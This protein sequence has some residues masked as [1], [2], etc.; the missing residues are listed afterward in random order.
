MSKDYET[1]IGLEI[2]AELSTESK[3][4][5]GCG[6][7]FGSEV[8]TECCPVCI[9]LPG[10]LPV[11]SKKVVD[12][13][14]K[15]GLA[16]GCTIN[17]QSS[18]FRKNYFYPDLP[19]GYQIT[20]ADLPI[21]EGG[22]I[23]F[24][25]QGEKRS[26]RLIRIHLEEDTAKLVH[27]D[28]F[29]GTLLDFNR[30]GVPLIEI[31][32]E[33]DLRSPEEVKDYLDAVRMLLGTLDI[34]NTQMQEGTIR[35]DVNVS[36]RPVGQEA[37]GT[38]VEMKNVST[39]SGAMQAVA[40]E[41]ARQI[42]LLEEGKTFAQETRRWDE[43]KGESHPMRLKETAADYRYFPEADLTPLVVDDEWIEGVK[44]NL[45]ELPVPKYERYLERGIG[46]AEAKMLLEFPDRAAFFESAATGTVSS[47]KNLKNLANWIF[48]PVSAIS[49][50]TAVA[51]EDSKLKP[52]DLC[53][54][55]TMVE[56]KRIN[57]DA[58]R[59][60][61]EEIFT[62]GGTAEEVVKKL[63][64]EQVSDE[65]ALKQLVSEVL[66]ANEK[67]IEDYRNGKKNAFTFLVGQCMKASKGKGNPQVVNELLKAAL[68]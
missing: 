44:K 22:K 29:E 37:F 55:L 24:Y 30:C 8:N 36:V 11:L 16:A 26:V 45:P 63:S 19:H 39:F 59:L 42:K 32:S 58:G 40:Y 4:F 49:K 34:C 2:H 50:K 60:V 13:A 57:I 20:Q 38:R 52:G 33:P 18:F 41:S 54:I 28:S 65:G 68:D 47:N 5:C 62:S 27:D 1:I 31:V 51:F 12:Y 7:H 48:G 9:G 61:M 21:C 43:N 15:I 10:A 53:D 23:E 46:K 14:L 3:A 64:L 6:Y 67:S 56:Q 66:A 17:K 25:H 35:C